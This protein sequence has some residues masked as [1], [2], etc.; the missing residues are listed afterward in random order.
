MRISGQD[1]GRGTF[2]HRHAVLNDQNNGEAYLPLQ[3]IDK[4]QGDFLVINS[5]LSEEAV[6]A[7]EFGYAA[8]EPNALVV[9]EAQFG[10]FANGAQVV[11]DQFIASSE[12]K[13]D[14]YCGLVL[15]LPHGYD[16]QGPE[17]SPARLERFSNCARDKTCKFAIPQPQPIFHMLRRQIRRPYRKPLIVMSPKSLLRKGLSFSPLEEF[18][19]G[20]Y[21]PVLDETEKY[22]NPKLK[23][24]TMLGKDLFRSLRGK[25]EKQYQGL[26]YYKTGAVSSIP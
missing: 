14:R 17:H 3:N 12:E 18:T 6:L 21:Q 7:F 4:N 1:C 19:E 24:Y 26:R 25:G 5:T 10:D 20:K 23:N 15:F 16:G 13:W 11:I 9:W 2:S 22:Q 8:A